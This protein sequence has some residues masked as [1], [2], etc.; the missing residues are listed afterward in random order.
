[1]ASFSRWRVLCGLDESSVLRRQRN[2]SW[3]GENAC[4]ALVLRRFRSKAPIPEPSRMS[5]QLAKRAER[6]MHA[7]FP[8]S[9]GREERCGGEAERPGSEGRAP[10]PALW[11]VVQVTRRSGTGEAQI[12]ED[13]GMCTKDHIATIAK[14]FPQRPRTRIRRPESGR[15]SL[16]AIS[17]LLILTLQAG[18]L[19]QRSDRRRCAPCVVTPGT[20]PYV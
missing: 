12:S 9:A 7:S 2:L 10:S 17:L 16:A 19:F 5:R 14:S 4:V 1:M 20:V 15:F 8:V 6:S 11:S 18:L 13:A 3:I